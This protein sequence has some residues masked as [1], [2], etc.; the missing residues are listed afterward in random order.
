MLEKAISACISAIEIYNKPNF[1][2]REETFN[3]NDK[4]MGTSS[5]IQV[6]KR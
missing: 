3:S 1:Q 6:G 5:K 2:H 4:C